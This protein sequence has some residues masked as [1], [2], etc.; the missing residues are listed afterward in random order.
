MDFSLIFD[1]VI[2]SEQRRPPGN[3]KFRVDSEIKGGQKD[4]R[5]LLSKEFTLWRES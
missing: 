1:L 4:E 3:I 2:I 5:L